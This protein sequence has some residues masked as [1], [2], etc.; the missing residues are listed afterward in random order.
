[1][2]NEPRTKKSIVM[3]LQEK[4]VKLGLIKADKRKIKADIE[5]YKNKHT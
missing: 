5:D 1:M 2:E 4:R 3:Y